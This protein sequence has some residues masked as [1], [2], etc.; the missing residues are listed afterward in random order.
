MSKIDYG[1]QIYGKTTK[2]AIKKLNSP[3]HAAIRLSLRAFKSTKI[4]NILAEG[5]L[6]TIEDRI[7]YLRSRSLGLLL[8]DKTSILHTDI[9]DL[10]ARK[11]PLKINSAL[12]NMLNLLLK[13]CITTN[14]KHTIHNLP[15]WMFK[16]SSLIENLAIYSKTNTSAEMYR[17]LFVETTTPLKKEKTVAI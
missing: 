3:Y 5:D 4:E 14:S 7:Q 8:C 15:P 1:L 6:Y 9:R 10:K 12:S 13:T 16:D 11:T 17:K 2:A